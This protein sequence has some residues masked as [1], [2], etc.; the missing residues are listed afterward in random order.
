MPSN[1]SFV[2]VLPEGDGYGWGVCGKQLN[3]RLNKMLGSVPLPLDDKY[4]KEV[5]DV[6]L[7]AI[8]GPDWSY[9]VNA[10][11]YVNIGYGFIEHRKIA[12][13][14]RWMAKHNW[15]MI[16]AG[17]EYMKSE[18]RPIVGPSVQVEVVIQGADPDVFKIR[19]D[20]RPDDNFFTI[21]SFGK[22]EFRKSQDVVA[23]AV[24][25]FSKTHKNV[26]L[27]HAWENRWTALVDEFANY[28]DIGVTACRVTTGGDSLSD[29]TGQS[30]GNYVHN[31]LKRAG[32]PSGLEHLP[33]N[34]DLS[35]VYGLCDVALFPNRVE[36]GTNLCLHE[37]LSSGVPCIA[38][39]DH[40]HGDLIEREDYPCSDLSL[41]GQ[42]LKFDDRFD[43]YS[44]P[45]LDEVIS[46]LHY[47]YNRKAELL[48]R[49][50]DVSYFGH[51]FTWN[52][53]ADQ[54]AGIVRLYGV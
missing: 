39:N 50:E 14:Y 37:A 47:A 13:R 52:R 28:S 49:R 18:I 20:V 6:C 24:A 41:N 27:I 17:S 1:R 33:V 42:A 35:R 2:S 23:K 29:Y 12:D 38:I 9:S 26:R 31:M 51:R 25:I 5:A 54:M 30:W 46:K 21:G 48:D 32:A 43:I 10:R 40:G 15:D 45:C 34:G 8:A 4:P 16:V 3:S 11:G 53:S 36:A 19:E 7:Q 44:E 22:F